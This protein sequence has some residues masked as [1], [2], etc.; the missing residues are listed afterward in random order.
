MLEQKAQNQLS[1]PSFNSG[2]NTLTIIAVV[3]AILVILALSG[4][5][6]QRKSTQDSVEKASNGTVAIQDNGK[7]TTIETDDGEI[8][9]GQGEIP[10]SFPPDVTV[11]KSAEVQATT[12]AEDSI[13]ITLKTPDSIS[14]ITSFYKNDLTKNGWGSITSNTLEGSS[15]ITAKKD[16]RELVITA[17]VDEQDNKTEIVIVVGSIQ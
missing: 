14:K 11:Y 8:T 17:T 3:V 6:V 12:E 4:Y 15:L 10:K 2:S 7:K 13:S 16:E 5:F 1:K 9:I